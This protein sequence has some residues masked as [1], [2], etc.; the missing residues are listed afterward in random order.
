MRGGLGGAVAEVVAGYRPCPMRMLGFPGFM[1]TGS[2]DFL[3]EKCG[4]TP[5][6][7]ERAAREAMAM[8]HAS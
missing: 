3:F 5:G 6:G 8:R 4:L 7:I 1:P 2:V